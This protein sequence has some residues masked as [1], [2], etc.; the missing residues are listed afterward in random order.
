MTELEYYNRASEH[1]IKHYGEE[2]HPER[3]TL[4][5]VLKSVA[6]AMRDEL[7][8]ELKRLREENYEFRSLQVYKNFENEIAAL[9]E[10]CDSLLA[11]AMAALGGSREDIAE[12]LHEWRNLK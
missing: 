7:L 11:A 3:G 10:K 2:S 12:A 9:N 5:R 8:E 6:D 1:P 4:D